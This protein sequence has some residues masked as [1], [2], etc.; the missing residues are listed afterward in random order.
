MSWRAALC[1]CFHSLSYIHT[2]SLFLSLLSLSHTH[3][4]SLSI[5]LSLSLQWTHRP[6]GCV[7][8]LCNNLSLAISMIGTAE[9]MNLVSTRENV[10]FSSVLLLM[11]C[12]VLYC[13]VLYCTAFCILYRSALCCTAMYCTVLYCI[14]CATAYYDVL[15]WYIPHCTLLSVFPLSLPYLTLLC[16]C[17]AL[18][19][20]T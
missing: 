8:K 19:D 10:L 15:Y 9:A 1:S 4:H 17:T 12:I 16:H 6:V 3:T 14:Y 13:T 18:H 2:F 20:N 5:S 7:A 11:D